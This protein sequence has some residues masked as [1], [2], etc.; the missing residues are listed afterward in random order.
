MRD[1]NDGSADAL[2]VDLVLDEEQW[3]Q[4]VGRRGGGVREGRRR[5]K[6]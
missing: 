4:T 5:R 2:L 1:W 3:E 6:G